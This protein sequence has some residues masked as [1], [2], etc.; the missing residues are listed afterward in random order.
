MTILRP[1]R[2]GVRI[3]SETQKSLKAKLKFRLLADHA[4]NPISS[5]RTKSA[6]VQYSNCCLMQ[7]QTERAGRQFAGHGKGFSFTHIVMADFKTHITVSTLLGVAYGGVGYLN[8]DLPPAHCL[9]ATSLCSVS[10]MLPD[11]DSNSSVPQREMLCFVSV[12]VPLLMMPRFQA[13]GLSAEQM[14][15][16]AGVLYVLIRFGI[17]G[18]F[19]R[20][21]KHR[22]MWHSI[23]AAMIA[24]MATFLVCL[25]TD[26][27]IR[28][29]KSW[30]VVIGFVSH[31]ILDEIYAVDWQGRQIRVKSSF[32]TALKLFST[33][34]WANLVT[35]GKLILLTAMIFSDHYVMDCVCDQQIAVPK[36]ASDW[37]HNWFSHDADHQHKPTL[38]R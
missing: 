36:T 2:G 12:I 29:F 24:G 28:L 26:F 8:Y 32:G 13:L 1:I 31:L 21:T 9:I 17:G 3:K 15:F 33:S 20:Y 38:T 14:V 35:Y 19:R 27:E 37:L 6:L 25:S 30:A 4:I 7:C 10:G 23:P 22:G 5:N 34:R 18:I 11:L 16:V